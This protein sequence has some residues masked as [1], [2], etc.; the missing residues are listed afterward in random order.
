M[1]FAAIWSNASW[2]LKLVL[3]Q[4]GHHFGWAKLWDESYF[5]SRIPQ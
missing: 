1:M 5:R 4:A 3:H 2:V